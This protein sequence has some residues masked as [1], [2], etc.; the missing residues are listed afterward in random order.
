MKTFIPILLAF[1]GITLLVKGIKLFIKLSGVKEHTILPNKPVQ[2]FLDKPGK[3]NVFLLR[4]FEW[5][6]AAGLTIFNNAKVELFLENNT[7]IAFYKGSPITFNQGGN[8]FGTSYIQMGTFSNEMPN[9]TIN[10]LFTTPANN[11][12]LMIKHG[13]NNDKLL[14]IFSCVIGFMLSMAALF[15]YMIINGFAK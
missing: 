15:T 11:S 8:S 1:A 6:L 4:S 3:Y 10:I 5:K 2:V 12:K 7:P 14:A 9:T 13:S